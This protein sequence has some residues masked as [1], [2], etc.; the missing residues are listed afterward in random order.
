VSVFLHLSR[1]SVS[2]AITGQHHPEVPNAVV[3]VN[4]ETPLGLQ[5]NDGVVDV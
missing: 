4:V 1:I 3:F 5:K 2:C